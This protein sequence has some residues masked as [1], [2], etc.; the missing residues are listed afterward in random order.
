MLTGYPMLFLLRFDLTAPLKG[1]FA[2]IYRSTEKISVHQVPRDSVPA[3][4]ST[5]IRSLRHHMIGK[6]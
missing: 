2:R 5:P 4:V 6:E 3:V 1:F